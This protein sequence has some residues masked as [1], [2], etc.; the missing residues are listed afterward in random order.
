M[1]TSALVSEW[2]M[3]EVLRN[4]EVQRKAQAELD[5][6]VGRD[7]RV[8][9]SDLPNL[10]YLK[11]VVKEALRLHPI[12]PTL[13]PH[14]S[15]T[16]CKA[17]GYDIPARTQLLVNVWAIGRDPAVW[18]DPLEFDPERFLGGGRHA[19]TDFG[20]KAFE[21]LPFGSGRRMCMGMPLG[22]LL[23]EAG[24]A[25]LLH[26]FAWSLPTDLDMSEGAG[27]SAKKAVPLCAVA[28]SRLPSPSPS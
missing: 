28:S 19:Q 26:C 18:A 22:A 13:V 27:L 25:T 16:A 23:V 5:E 17:F 6:V 3:A 15:N 8:R 21:L 24:V 20:G 4:P 2:T 1:E 9:E 14:Q 11:A 10:K 7:R 12:I